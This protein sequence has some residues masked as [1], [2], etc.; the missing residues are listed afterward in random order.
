MSANGHNAA[1]SG[2]EGPG[3]LPIGAR[4]ERS[5]HATAEDAPDESNTQRSQTQASNGQQT[6][7][8]TQQPGPNASRSNTQQPGPNRSGGNTQQQGR[9][10]D[11]GRAP[12]AGR[13]ARPSGRTAGS[14]RTTRLARRNGASGRA[15][16]SGR[17]NPQT[18]SPPGDVALPSIEDEDG[19]RILR[20]ERTKAVE[21]VL[22]SQ[23]GDFWAM[24]A[25]DA[26]RV[27]Q[28]HARNQYRRLS[29]LLHP[30]KHPEADRARAQQAQS[31]QYEVPNRRTL[32]LTISSAQCRK[33]RCGFRARCR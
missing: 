33:G 32:P 7:N 6:G 31:R 20:G 22:G 4:G 30:D 12:P 28:S 24:L 16:S 8:T 19:R 9:N 25:L 11:P 17:T 13:A 27:T 14:G 3:T 5:R 15:A 29:L 10:D 1:I 26:S 18:A 2:D 21:R 23:P